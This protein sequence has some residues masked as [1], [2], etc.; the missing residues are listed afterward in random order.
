[1]NI[2]KPQ[3]T[4][5]ADYELAKTNKGTILIVDDVP[6]NIGV[7]FDFLRGFGLKI[8][9]A[10]DGESG[11]KK[12]ENAQP[13]MILLDVMMPGIDGFET[14]KRLKANEATKNIPVIF[15]TALSDTPFAVKGFELGAVDY[16]NK[17]IQQEEVLARINVQLT[18]R[19]YTR[20]LKVQNEQ[21]I[22]I[23]DRLEKEVSQRRKAENAL[24]EANETLR[25]LASLDGLT[26]I[27]NRRAFDK[28]LIEEWQRASRNQVSLALILCDVDHF[29][30]YNDAFGHPA[31]DECLRQVASAISHAAQR[32]NDMVARYGGE[33]FA[34][35]M[36]NVTQEDLVHIAEAIQ[37]NIKTLQI[38]APPSVRADSQNSQ[39]VSISLGLCLSYPQHG[40]SSD[41]LLANADMALYE[42][43][44][45]G[46]NCIKQ[47]EFKA[48]EVEVE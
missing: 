47:K 11:I 19:Q 17:P 22:E 38:S 30:D 23:N 26:G 24:A 15:M 7:L 1:L 12:A 40:I 14:C 3:L 10:S 9:I 42:A 48:S 34:V 4:K 45:C 32:R 20:Q 2:H 43:K 37:E 41:F 44:S 5:T 18:L 35:L 28:R 25:K 8:L 13:D 46:R 36:S 29:K 27:S 33:E 6:A 21:L 31:G 39:C 16:I